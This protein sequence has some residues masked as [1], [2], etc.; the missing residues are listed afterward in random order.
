[1]T[2]PRPDRFHP[3]VPPPGF[4]LKL[5]SFWQERRHITPRLQLVHTNAA[6][7]EGSIEASWRWSQRNTEPGA[8]H[9]NPVGSKYYT[10][11]HFQVDRDGSGALLLPLDR[12]SITNARA[13]SFSIGIE[14]ADSGYLADP[15]ISAFTD[16]QAETV[17]VALAYAA[18]GYQIP[19][20]YPTAWDGTG[21]ACHTEP[22]GYPYWTIAQR[23]DMSRL[24]EES[25]GA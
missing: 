18:W 9:G 5:V 15:S 19:L 16:K 3:G 24:E 23:Q 11:P 2:P 20:E 14:T 4:L 6:S 13:N 7:R 25:T 1:M 22:F 12:Q 17:A 21:S 8:I 10:I